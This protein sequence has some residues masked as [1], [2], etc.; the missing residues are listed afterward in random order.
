VTTLT[1]EWCI[2]ACIN[3]PMDRMH[4]REGL[5]SR[6]TMSYNHA[7]GVHRSVVSSSIL[8]SFRRFVKDAE[9]QG[10]VVGRGEVRPRDY[11]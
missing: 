11:A 4:A 10:V 3:F 8:L 1:T 5:A 7:Y 6:G 2:I 9:L